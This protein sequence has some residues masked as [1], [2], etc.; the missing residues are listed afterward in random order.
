MF[1][2]SRLKHVGEAFKFSAEGISGARRAN[3]HVRSLYYGR[4]ESPFAPSNRNR[5]LIDT[6]C[7]ESMSGCSGSAGTLLIESMVFSLDQF[8]MQATIPQVVDEG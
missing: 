4:H 7:A 3:P 1:G 8:E 5:L 2:S 6:K